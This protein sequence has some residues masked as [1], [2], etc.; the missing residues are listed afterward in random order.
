MVGQTQSHH[1]NDEDRSCV[2]SFDYA[3]YNFIQII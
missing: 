3:N 2:F 1:G